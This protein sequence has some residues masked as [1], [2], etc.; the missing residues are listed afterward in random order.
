M[1]SELFIKKKIDKLNWL[2]KSYTG[3]GID[4]KRGISPP[5]I[6]LVFIQNA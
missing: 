1:R 4:L 3:F 5:S 6:E 2:K